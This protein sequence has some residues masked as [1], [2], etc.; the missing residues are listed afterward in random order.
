MTNNE[1]KIYLITP[2]KIN[3]KIFYDSLEKIFNSKIVSCL[4]IRLKNEEDKKIISIC[5]TIK[6]ICEKYNISLIINDRLD[7]VRKCKADG[8]HLGEEDQPIK[9]ARKIL[10]SNYIV[11]ASCYNSKHL[12]ILAAEN[13]ADYVAFGAFFESN[14]KVPKTNVD[15]SIIEDWNFISCVPCVAIGGITPTNCKKLVQAGVDHIAVIGSIW[16]SNKTPEE[17]ILEFKKILN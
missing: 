2:P 5:N 16:N 4:Q 12:A 17:A 9:Y 1:T 10:G 14:T 7:L 15:I 3:E 8:V 11:G 6:P 13:G